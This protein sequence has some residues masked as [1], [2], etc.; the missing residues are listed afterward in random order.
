M[1]AP[2]GP[3]PPSLHQ[4]RVRHEASQGD[5]LASYGWTRH[6]GRSYGEQSLVDGE[7]NI[8]VSMV[9]RGPASAWWVRA[10]WVTG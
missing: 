9:G 4:M 3:H 2:R 10:V 1:R 7:Y 5:G 6:D 8:S